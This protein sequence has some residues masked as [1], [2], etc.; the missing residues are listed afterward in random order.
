VVNPEVITKLRAAKENRA[1]PNRGQTPQESVDFIPQGVV[2]PEV[3]RSL[4][5]AKAHLQSEAAKL[6]EELL[7]RKVKLNL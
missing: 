4:R 3:I 1:N 6:K 7:A 2:D 5:A